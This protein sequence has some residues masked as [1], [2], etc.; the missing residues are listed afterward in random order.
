MIRIYLR[1]GATVDDADEREILDMIEAVEDANESDMKPGWVWL[2]GL[3]VRA[4]EVIGFAYL[5]YGIA[6]HDATR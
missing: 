3:Y 6:T 1:N 4:V 5:P 2:A